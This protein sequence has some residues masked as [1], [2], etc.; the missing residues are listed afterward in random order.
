LD[1][2]EF[3]FHGKFGVSSF[4]DT[5]TKVCIWYPERKYT[6][7]DGDQVKWKSSISICRDSHCSDLD[8][9][10]KHKLSSR[11]YLV[12]S[13]PSQDFID[14]F[15][16]RFEAISSNPA[17]LKISE[18]GYPTGD[19]ILLELS[20]LLW[21]EHLTQS[22][23]DNAIEIPRKGAEPVIVP[24]E[25]EPHEP[26]VEDDDNSLFYIIVI[27]ILVICTALT[28]G[29]L[30]SCLRSQPAQSVERQPL[31]ADNDRRFQWPPYVYAAPSPYQMGMPPAMM[32]VYFP[33]VPDGQQASPT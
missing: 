32:G 12:V 9:T 17:P 11:Q 15:V 1:P 5:N 16:F 10:T 20:D 2:D 21:E 19:V 4:L 23:L 6:F 7:D 13:T 25:E 22:R 28:I 8:G 27:G 18:I 26:E 33:S 30:L 24:H 3:T 31:I 29:G 14:D